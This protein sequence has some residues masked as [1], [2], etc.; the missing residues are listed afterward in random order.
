MLKKVIVTLCLAL[1]LAGSLW[2]MV[3]SMDEVESKMK[4]ETASQRTMETMKETEPLT[5]EPETEETENATEAET[6]IELVEETSSNPYAPSL[7]L[8]NSQVVLN[9]GESLDLIAQVEDV[10]DDSDDYYYLF[11]NISV[12]GDYDLDTPGEYILTYTV[13]DSNGNVSAPRYLKVIVK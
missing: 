13:A 8:R 10:S 2:C 7:K 12:S 3:G 1:L 9:A 5:E 6:E 11:R 4:L